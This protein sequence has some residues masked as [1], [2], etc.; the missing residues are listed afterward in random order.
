MSTATENDLALLR[1]VS[2]REAAELL[3]YSVSQFDRLKLVEPV[4]VVENGH[5][6]FRLADVLVL[7]E[8]EE[9]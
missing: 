1:L 6:R 7:M 3:G 2:A 4:R 9:D 8:K 5:R